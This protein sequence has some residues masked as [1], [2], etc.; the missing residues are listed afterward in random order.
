MTA[1]GEKAGDSFSYHVDLVPTWYHE[2]VVSNYYT[3]QY[4]FHKNAYR[5]VG[6]PGVV[7]FNYHI[8]GLVVQVEPREEDFWVF[9]IHLCAIIGG[10]FA[11]CKALY[12][13]V[14]NLLPKF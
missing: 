2:G 12:N 14:S 4:T 3:Y 13:W 6:Q 5:A 10:A 8:G 9:L 7:N 1:V 11:V